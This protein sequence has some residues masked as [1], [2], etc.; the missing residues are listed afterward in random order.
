MVRWSV[1]VKLMGTPVMVLP[2]VSIT[3]A[4][5]GCGVFGATDTLVLPLAE[6]V[7]DFG[8]QVWKTPA[9]ELVPA[10]LAVIN[11]EPGCLAVARP[12]WSM[13]TMVFWDPVPA[14]DEVLC[15]A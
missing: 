15:A 2:L 10:M 5:V 11:A 1:E 4:V 7:I 13:E 14:F 8:G 6:S 12:F 3:V 9:L